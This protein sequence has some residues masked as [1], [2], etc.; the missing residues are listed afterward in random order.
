MVERCVEHKLFKI[1]AMAE[2]CRG[3]RRSAGGVRRFAEIAAGV[4]WY[5]EILEHDF[6]LDVVK[7]AGVVWR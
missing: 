1:G 6:V 4:R 2:M 5:A 3:M 7:L